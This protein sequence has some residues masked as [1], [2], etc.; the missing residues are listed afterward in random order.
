MDCGKSY[1]K[2]LS[3]IVLNLRQSRRQIRANGFG[4][5]HFDDYSRPSSVSA[6]NGSSD[7]PKVSRKSLAIRLLAQPYPKASFNNPGS[8]LIRFR[9]SLSVSSVKI[10]SFPSS[11]CRTSYVVSV[12]KASTASV[13]NASRRATSLA[14]RVT[15]GWPVGSQTVSF[16]C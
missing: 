4:Q 9:M 13:G 5:E 2:C 3:I 8:P 12:H 15:D 10:S 11:A 14:L 16:R 6:M 7:C 1:S